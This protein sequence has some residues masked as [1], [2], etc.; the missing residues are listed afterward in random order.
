MWFMKFRIFPIPY[1]PARA[2]LS[3][4]NGTFLPFRR[5]YI[6]ICTPAGGS[7]T[8]NGGET[9][10]LTGPEISADE[11]QTLRRVMI[12][13][14]H[15]I[16]RR[17]VRHA[18]KGKPGFEIVAEVGSLSDAMDAAVTRQPDL[19][20]LDLVLGGRDG[21]EGIGELRRALPGAGIL[22]FSMNPE[23]VF[24]PL[25]LQAG[26]NGYLTKS[27]G[28]DEL[29]LALMEVVNGGTYLSPLM[30]RITASGGRIPTEIDTFTDREMQ[31]FLRIGEGKTTSEIAYELNLSVKTV[32]THRDKLKAK[33]GARSGAEL[34]RRAIAH[35]IAQGRFQPAP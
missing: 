9:I 4:I 12:V 19:V 26:A 14:D 21:I 17:G 8:I 3:S 1:C 18:L 29:H 2:A 23:E 5:K 34:A 31:V 7:D 33:L 16:M 35:V 6:A 25:A 32:F 27:A 28:Y 13:D 24:A 10:H 30:A 22:V 20:V 15:P 11:S